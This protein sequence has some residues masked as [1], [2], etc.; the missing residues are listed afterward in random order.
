VLICLNDLSGSD[1]IVDPLSPRYIGDQG[2]YPIGNILGSIP[3][4]VTQDIAF[5]KRSG[6]S[7][8]LDGEDSDVAVLLEFLNT[9]FEKTQR[10]VDYAAPLVPITIGF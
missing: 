10:I 7:I 4:I 9:L 6:P 3:P 1:V 5:D 2:D 8:S